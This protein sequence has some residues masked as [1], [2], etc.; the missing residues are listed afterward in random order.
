MGFRQRQAHLI[1]G[2]YAKRLEKSKGSNTGGG[3]KELATN[4]GH[5]GGA[6]EEG[7]GR[8]D[9]S[10]S[11][12]L[13]VRDLRHLGHGGDSSGG[14]DLTVGDLRDLGHGGGGHGRRADGSGGL[15]LAV[16][17]LRDLGS[18]AGGGGSLDLTIGD[19]SDLGGGAGGS[20]RGRAGRGT[21]SGGH[22]ERVDQD[23]C[24][25]RSA[26]VGVKVVEAAGQALG[27]DI[28]AAKSERAVGADGETTSVESAGLGF[29]CIELELVV[30]RNVSVASLG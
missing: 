13:A 16:G 4:L 25:L 12:D 19:L 30:C 20:R 8:G 1:E 28:A 3:G 15:D 5:H 24:A 11:L 29:I 14:L 9:G 27:E 6:G 10:G 18:G 26:V 7:R 22:G 23:R 2:R 21:G 17:N